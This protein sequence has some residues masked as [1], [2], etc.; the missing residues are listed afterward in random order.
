MNI[1]IKVLFTALFF[2]M[3]DSSN[4]N[5]YQQTLSEPL[6]IE[7][8]GLHSGI[9]VSMKLIPAESNTGIK[10]YR[11]DLKKNNEI[12][13]LWS[14]V[15][16]TQLSTTISNIYGA[17]VSTIE[18][19]MSALSGLH[20]DNLKIE[21]NGPEVP[22]MD[23]SSKDFVD[24]IES[25]PLKNLN[26]KRKIILIKKNIKVKNDNGKVELKPNNQFS[27]DFEIDFPSKIISKQSC[28]L[29]L[30]NGNY[31]TDIASARTFGFEKDVDKLR[32]NGLALGG[33]L[34]NAVVVGENRILNEE[35][36]RFK[37]EFV[38]HKILDSIGDLYLAGAP[39]QGYFL[40]S[41][42]GHHL[43]N[44]LLKSLFSDESNYEFI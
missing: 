41:K 14:N 27:I 44:L 24:L 32:S 1:S 36:L 18:H 42:S 12:D 19:L 33:S 26:Q 39:I 3:I 13:A 7:G 11:T 21:I 43:N 10:F 35:G 4:N 34:E 5:T 28:Q 17:K 30:V 40:G 16:N 2:I 23:G 20:I 22:I 25:I 29:Q 37:D 38:R 15:S 9:E 8:I 31:K 6:L